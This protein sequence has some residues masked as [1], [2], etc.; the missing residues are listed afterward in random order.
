[1]VVTAFDA[2]HFRNFFSPSDQSTGPLGAP[3]IPIIVCVRSPR[4]EISEN[5][6]LRVTKRQIGNENRGVPSPL[7]PY[8]GLQ[9]L[10]LPVHRYFAADLLLFGQSA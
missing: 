3:K 4:V 9:Y 8:K 10:C 5:R 7:P 1:M 2:L 6:P